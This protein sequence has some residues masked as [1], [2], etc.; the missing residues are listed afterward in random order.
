MVEV[1]NLQVPLLLHF[2]FFFYYLNPFS[3]ETFSFRGKTIKL[4]DDLNHCVLC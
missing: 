2:P 3:H 4:E 1:C